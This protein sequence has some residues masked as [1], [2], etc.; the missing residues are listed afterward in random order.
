MWK[1]ASNK[2]LGGL[3]NKPMGKDMIY[4]RTSWCCGAIPHPHTSQQYVRAD[5]VHGTLSMDKGRLRVPRRL[6]VEER[7]EYAVQDAVRRA[8]EEQRKN[9]ERELSTLSDALQ[10]CDDT[11]FVVVSEEIHRW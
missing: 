8:L 11:P 2:R 10:R 5:C 9:Q 1:F 4:A 7:V 6:S 3:Y